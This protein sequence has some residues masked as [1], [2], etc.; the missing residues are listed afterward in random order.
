MEG[1]RLSMLKQ[2]RHG[3]LCGL[4]RQSVIPYVHGEDYCIVVCGVVQALS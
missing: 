2:D 1:I 3:S 4:G